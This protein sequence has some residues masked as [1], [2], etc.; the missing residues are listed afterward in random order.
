L[1]FDRSIGSDIL[2]LWGE[3][4]LRAL[5]SSHQPQGVTVDWLA[6]AG[7]RTGFR[8]TEWVELFRGPFGDAE[9]LLARLK[10]GNI[11]TW[12][13]RLEVARGIDEVV[14]SVPTQLEVE[15][16]D[17]LDKDEFGPG[18]TAPSESHHA[19]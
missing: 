5:E 8:P 15:V 12:W 9:R 10:K 16:K 3:Q 11:P 7:I 4:I 17:L 6:P 2:D 18:V 13:T 19:C 14:I 1:T